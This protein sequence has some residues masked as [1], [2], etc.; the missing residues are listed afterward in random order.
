MPFFFDLHTHMLCGVD[1]GAKTEEE[2]YAML[3]MAY[4]DGTRALC[5]TP[6]YSPYLFGDTYEASEASFALLA[7]YV[8]KRHPDM[9]LYLGH[10][11]GYHVAVA[12]GFGIGRVGKDIVIAPGIALDKL[13]TIALHHAAA[14]QTRALEI[15]PGHGAGLAR[16][17]HHAGAG[18]ATAQG[19]YAHRAGTAEQIQHACS[20]NGG[21]EDVE[22]CFT[23]TVLGRAH[24][25][26]RHSDGETF[27]CSCDDSHGVICISCKTGA[28]G[29]FCLAPVVWG[30]TCF[31]FYFCP[32]RVA[33]A[34]AVVMGKMMV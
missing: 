24:F 30:K 2:M 18:G 15:L 32:G 6:H 12:Y 27:G 23:H 8:A 11:L 31:P 22:E 34:L 4:A 26:L 7:D 14:H 5:V 1:D 28:I 3:E 9:Y 33:R 20:L 21:A 16:G 29:G 13:E 10:E 25:A 19:L 17:I